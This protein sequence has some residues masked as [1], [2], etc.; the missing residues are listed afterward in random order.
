MANAANTSR[1]LSWTPAFGQAGSYGVTFTAANALTGSATTAITVTDLDRA[2]VVTAPA[3][4][5]G[6]EGTLITFTVSA[7][8]RTATPSLL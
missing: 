2:P 7:A 4:A 5:S 8:D 1:T 3:T 6:N